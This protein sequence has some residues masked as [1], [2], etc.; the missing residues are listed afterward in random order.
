MIPRCRLGMVLE[1]HWAFDVCVQRTAHDLWSCGGRERPLITSFPNSLLCG[2]SWRAAVW[3]TSPEGLACFKGAEQ[4][5][6]TS[7]LLHHSWE[8]PSE[9]LEGPLS[10]SVLQPPTPVPLN[11]VPLTGHLS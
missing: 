9:L 2:W 7:G 10:F 5:T 4:I 8:A 11:S 3:I 1:S 6:E